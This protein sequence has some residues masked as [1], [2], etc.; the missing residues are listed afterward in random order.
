MAR[1][2][3]PVD[4]ALREALASLGAS[5]ASPVAVAYSGGLDSSVLLAAAASAVGPSRVLA[6]HVHHGLQPA[7][8]GWAA[9][10]L[11]QSRAWGL[12]LRVL[13][14]RGG[15]QP[16]DSVEQWARGERYRLLLAAAHEAGAVALLTAHHA[17]DQLETLLL[18]LSRG[19]GLDGLT[20]IAPA[21]ERDGVRLL[22]P[23]LEF[24]RPTLHAYALAHRLDWVEDPSNLD[25]RLPRNAVRARVLP[26]LR[27]T[28]P[29][30]AAQLPTALAGLREAREVIDAVAATDLAGARITGTQVDRRPL[31]ELPAA[32]LSGALRGWMAALGALPPNRAR[33][34]Q[35]RTQLVLGPGPHA[36]IRH[37]GWRLLRH[38][39]TLSALPAGVLQ[40][41]QP[42]CRAWSGEPEWRLP[43]AGRLCFTSTPG[44]L[45]PQWLR[46]CV[47]RVD[48]V[49]SS[50]RLRPD[51][52]GPSR[53]LKNLRQ[54]AGVPA[55]VRALLPGV[56]VGGRLLYAA[57]FGLDRSPD[58]PIAAVG[59]APS[60]CPDP[61]DPRCA[62][63]AA[64]P[65]SGAA[66]LSAA[67]RRPRPASR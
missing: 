1:S 25:E 53:S 13:R 4:E 10:C 17:D 56:W 60:W 12:P 65:P 16:G 34:A 2:R 45:D 46:G 18:A 67:S 57:G 33:L 63:V 11:A 7:A 58:W 27:R 3:R 36:E 14:A 54:E 59:V 21:D 26:V 23:L 29:G 64:A 19:C 66:G 39:D 41:L 20:G 43:G 52:G 38:R 42:V 55:W 9:H 15:P 28:L 62:I 48:A 35:M 37:G 47:L 49:P 24:D 51:P 31:A 50:A 61:D 40:P 32:R 44:G 22:R 6:L 30:L 5:A 8:E